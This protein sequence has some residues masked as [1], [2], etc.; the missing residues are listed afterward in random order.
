MT[1]ETRLE[2]L[3]ILEDLEK[4]EPDFEGTMGPTQWEKNQLQKD[5]NNWHQKFDK[6]RELINQREK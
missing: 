3:A 1:N 6:I 4:S 5:K 2:I